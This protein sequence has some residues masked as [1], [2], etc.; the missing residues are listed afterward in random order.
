MPR[1]SNTPAAMQ[2]SK[3]DTPLLAAGFLIY[4]YW[5][6]SGNKWIIIGITGC[7]FGILRFALGLRIDFLHFIENDKG[8]SF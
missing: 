6:F 5:L 2:R 4:I 3:L 1:G 8:I 7:R